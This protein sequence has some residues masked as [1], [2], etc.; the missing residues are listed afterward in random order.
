MSISAFQITE[1]LDTHPVSKFPGDFQSLLE[2][3]RY[4]YTACNPIDSSRIRADLKTFNA[5]TV[6]LT[7]DESDQVFDVVSNLC[8]ELERE[9]FAHGIEVG[10]D[11]DNIK[12]SIAEK[13]LYEVGMYLM[14]ELNALP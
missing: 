2:M 9:S 12:D 11:A 5:L 10:M 14:T 7:I 4:I 13:Y 6:K 8:L 3:I 1:Y